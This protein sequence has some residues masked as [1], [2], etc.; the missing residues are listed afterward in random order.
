MRKINRKCTKSDSFK[1]SILISLHY[2]DITP[3]PKRINKL[4]KYTIHK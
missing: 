2:Y 3:H 1:Y 4:H